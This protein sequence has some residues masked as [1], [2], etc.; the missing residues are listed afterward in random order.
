VVYDQLKHLKGRPIKDRLQSFDPTVSSFVHARV[1]F[2]EM[3]TKFLSQIFDYYSHYHALKL[4]ELT[5]EEGS[6]WDQVWKE[7]EKQAVPGMI[8]PN[9]LIMAWFKTTGGGTHAHQ[10]S[11]RRIRS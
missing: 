5:H 3:T 7:A 11:Q 2:D 4:S 1:D 8:I 10:S 6:P 9:R